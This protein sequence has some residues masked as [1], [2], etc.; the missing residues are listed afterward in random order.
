MNALRFGKGFRV[1]I[2]NPRVQAA[3]MGISPGDSEGGP[4]TRHLRSDQWLLVTARTEIAIVTGQ[5]HRLK[6][7][8]DRELLL[9]AGL[10]KGR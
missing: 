7:L 8:Q 3:Q 6:P 9:A 2:G 1:L 5:R 4:K 10:Y